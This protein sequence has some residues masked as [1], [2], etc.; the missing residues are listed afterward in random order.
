M[1]ISLFGA[2]RKF[3]LREAFKQ[4]IP[5]A[6]SLLIRI[7][8]GEWYILSWNLGDLEHGRHVKKDGQKFNSRFGYRNY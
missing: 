1:L 5:L 6:T 3:I 4:D 7:F 2:K 8:N